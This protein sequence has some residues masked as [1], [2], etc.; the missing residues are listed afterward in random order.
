[1]I[2]LFWKEELGWKMG[3]LVGCG[4]KEMLIEFSEK[5]CLIIGDRLIERWYEGR[6]KLMIEGCLLFG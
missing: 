3:D 1:L 6:E 2:L 4:F 5:V